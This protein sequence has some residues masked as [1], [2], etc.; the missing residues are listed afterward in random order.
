MS[1]SRDVHDVL[2]KVFGFSEFLGQQEEVIKRTVRGNDSLVLM[3]TGGGKSLCYQIPAIVRNGV[4]VVV[5]PLIALMRDQVAGLRQAGVRAAYLNSTLSYP[6]VLNVEAAVRNGQV[7]LLYVA[8]E[9]LLGDR[10]QTLLE[11]SQLA[12]FAI[13]E[14]HCVSQWGHDFRPDYMKL[15]G[16]LERFP[17]VPRL[18]LT[19]TADEPTRREILT[20]L[21]LDRAVVFASGF[22]RPNIRY[23]VAAKNRPREQ[24][25]QFLAAHSG[26]SGIVYCLARR[27][28]EETAEW[29]CGIGLD[30]LPYHAGLESRVRQRN[31]DRFQREDGIVMAA[32]I[33]F[34]MG[35]DKP[36]VRFVAHL[37]M[38]KSIEAYYQ[39]TGRAGR[40]G[41][42]A[43][44]WMVFG[45]Q[46]V[47]KH[48]RMISQSGTELKRKQLESRRLSA[49]LGFC[50]AATCRRQALL[51]YF[52]SQF[53]P[54]CNDCDNCLTPVAT[55]DATQPSQMAL[56][57]V[58]RTGQ[59]FGATYLA[60]VL[61]GLPSDRIRNFGHDQIPTFGAGAELNAAQ[62][63]SVFRQ[64]V[65]QGLLSVDLDGYGSLQL[66]KASAAVLRGEESVR[67]RE[68][69]PAPR[70]ATAGTARKLLAEVDL[71]VR[72][73]SLWEALRALRLELARDQ[74]V[75]VFTI[76]HD[77]TLQEMVLRRPESMA[78]FARLRGV[79][80]AKLD[81]YGEQ[82]LAVIRR[83][84]EKLDRSHSSQ[85]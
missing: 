62:W 54:P 79:G 3:P 21:G 71:S 64:L 39:E 82:F 10:T 45:L 44:A 46:D 63:R 20:R 11:R 83:E 37:D 42:P 69:L 9:R 1:V 58:H 77:S 68:D 81:R 85:Q 41:E 61:R 76:F 60:D 12:V 19:A 2:N 47:A 36:D 51:A 26:E 7:D 27:S 55:W 65:A 73:G 5:S 30:A 78:E 8:P 53:D 6:E 35:I 18:A 70:A 40:D 29:L 72:Q 24:L 56:S 50:E 80:A 25:Q 67:L 52:G 74:E 31:Q 17:G 4:G 48:Q 49:L 22:D 66:T 16:V 75:P 43:E 84:R 23:L 33:A 13:D 28:A 14:A 57:C 38:P 34:G 15:A 59:R 32:T